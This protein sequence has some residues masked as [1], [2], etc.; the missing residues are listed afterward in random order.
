MAYAK[1]KSFD[2]DGRPFLETIDQSDTIEEHFEQAQSFLQVQKFDA[3]QKQYEHILSLYPDNVDAQIGL[4]DIA[5][6]QGQYDK[7]FKLFAV[8]AQF[9]KGKEKPAGIDTGLILALVLAE[10]SDT[11]ESD[12]KMAFAI[13]PNDTRV[14]NALGQLADNEQDWGKAREYY[15]QAL[16]TGRAT[17]RVLNNMGVSLLMQ[18][19]IREAIGKFRQAQSHDNTPAS[20][21]YNL[22][23][24]YIM[25][26]DYRRALSLS[27]ADDMAALYNDAGI[28]AMRDQKYALSK[29]LFQTAIDISP[30]YN[31]HAEENIKIANNLSGVPK[32]CEALSNTK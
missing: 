10:K 26:G 21:A 28:F 12:L 30:S 13:S 7:A 23:R 20:T 1:D 9:V 24:A 25:M 15:I 31:V 22:S 6:M 19:R 4:G 5:I 3:A 32:S 27:R 11:P 8:A 17:P 18:G 16:N 14:L 29:C 2:V